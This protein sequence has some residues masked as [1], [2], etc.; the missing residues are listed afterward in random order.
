MLIMLDTQNDARQSILLLRLLLGITSKPALLAIFLAILVIK[1]S[2]L[3]L[4][5]GSDMYVSC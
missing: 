1:F 2:G 5:F 4:R 3:M